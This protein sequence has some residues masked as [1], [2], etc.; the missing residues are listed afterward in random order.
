MVVLLT[1]QQPDAVGLAVRRWLA[2]SA[3]R[4]QHV[5]P[6][7]RQEIGTLAERVWQRAP[8]AAEWVLLQ[9]LRWTWSGAPCALLQAVVQLQQYGAAALAQLPEAAPAPAVARHLAC[10]RQ[11]H[12][13][14]WQVLS[15]LVRQ[16]LRVWPFTALFAATV[17]RTSC[18]QAAGLLAQLQRL[19]VVE[20]L[21][22]RGAGAARWQIPPEVWRWV[23]E[24]WATQG[25]EAPRW[26]RVGERCRLWLCHG[27][28]QE[29]GA[30][31][32]AWLRH[33]AA[34]G[35]RYL[36]R[37]PGRGLR[38]G[39]RLLFSSPQEL[40]AAVGFL[41]VTQELLLLRD[42]LLALVVLGS[43]VLG[44]GLGIWRLVCREPGLFEVVAA[45]WRRLTLEGLPRWRGWMLVLLPVHL[46][47]LG[48]WLWRVREAKKDVEKAGE[49]WKQ[50][51]MQEK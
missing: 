9:H 40:E 3:I 28:L 13:R 47:G 44:G 23:R 50:P 21:G 32:G 1:T 26:R 8:T 34:M 6:L 11:Q 16:S 4:E 39:Y 25:G 30:G 10:L 29:S 15:T 24:R 35:W 7:N 38:W 2:E 42:G 27:L 17:W 37:A 45:C 49:E 36:C 18:S 43:A 22:Q 31:W 51:E 12:A 33:Y 14:A 20:R 19:G 5:G 41:Q 46:V 48:W